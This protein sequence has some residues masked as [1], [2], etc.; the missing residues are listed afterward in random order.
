TDD[1]IMVTIGIAR[2]VRIFDWQD[3]RTADCPRKRVATSAISAMR[4]DRICRRWCRL[5]ETKNPPA[6]CNRRGSVRGQGPHSAKQS[7]GVRQP[8]CRRRVSPLADIAS[9]KK[10]FRGGKAPP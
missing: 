3:E 7:E 9:A 8:Q 5:R 2:D 10:Q 6:A 4:G 1:G